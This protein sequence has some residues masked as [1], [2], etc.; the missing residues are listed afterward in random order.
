M[1]G[2][3]GGCTYSHGDPTLVAPCD[4]SP[5][6]VTYAGVISPIFDAHC[7]ECHA[8]NKA[9]VL[10]G[11]NDF[12]D[13]QGIKRYPASGLLGSIEHA[14]GYDPMPKGLGKISECDIRRIK[15]WMDAGE[16]N[17]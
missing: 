13:Y 6:T 15:T 5:Q 8:S 1:L 16:P 12:G 14:P 7:R 11:S 4:A 3:A 17:N 9:A 10:G 2:L